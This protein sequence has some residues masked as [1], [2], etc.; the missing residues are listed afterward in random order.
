MR[1]LTLNMRGFGIFSEPTEIDFTDVELF[2]LTGPT[3]SGKTTVL[4]GICF[5]LY[6]AIPR[7]GEG[8][9]APVVNQQKNEASVVLTFAFNDATYSVARR[10]RRTAKGASTPDASLERDGTVL[11]ANASAVTAKVQELLG[12]DFRQFTTCVLLPQGEFARFLNEKQGKRQELL[13]ALLDL[14]LYDVIAGLATGRAREAEGKLAVL[15][16]QLV[17]LARITETDLEGLRTRQK[18]LDALSKTLGKSLAQLEQLGI[19]ATK[20]RNALETLTATRS[21]LV[22]LKPPRGWK[23]IGDLGKRLAASKDT[24]ATEIEAAAQEHTELLAVAHPARTQVA[25]YLEARSKEAATTVRITSL[26]NEVIQTKAVAV[27]EAEALALAERALEAA[28]NEDRAAHIRAGLKL[29]DLCPV[30]GEKITTLRASASGGILDTRSKEA[31]KARARSNKAAA[32]LQ[33]FES[34]LTR[35]EDRLRDL[36]AELEG[37]DPADAL[38]SQLHA[39]DDHKAG[40]DRARDRLANA[41][42]TAEFLDKK[43]VELNRRLEEVREGLQAVWHDL[44]PLGPPL[45]DLAQPVEAWDAILTWREM[46]LPALDLEGEQGGQRLAAINAEIDEAQAQLGSDLEAAGLD[47][48]LA[49]AREALAVALT[50]VTSDIAGVE[51]ARE[52][53]EQVG[54]ERDRVNA[55]RELAKKLAGELA[56]NKFKKWIFDEVFRALVEGANLRLA[57][58]TSGQYE[59]AVT[60]NDFEV[61]DRFAADKRRGVKSLSGGETFLVSL[62]LAIALADEV[63]A[64]AGSHVA[65]DSFFLDEGFG[66][67]DTESLDVV[68]RVIAELGAAGKT[69]GIVTHVEELADQMPVRY[70]VRR[71][72]GSGTVTQVGAA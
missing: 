29:G 62:A 14:G 23:E 32:T 24:V 6:G 44:T 52:A 64:A 9:V 48:D 27:A 26:V 33:T 55:E 7:H 2:A 56:A 59:L 71:V 39:I 13:G 21:V 37:I 25:R 36:A 69:V 63:A 18:E 66:T 10:V 68:A 57:D 22:G 4:D 61:I 1:P 16:Q 42:S 72:G 28:I 70:E 47:T 43:T 30:C 58:L 54:L 46:R 15:S 5:A 20:Q 67:L 45:L 41:R 17:E 60:D 51:E 8:S 40:L 11:A 49:G 50:T 34:E 65:L 53:V 31:D 35:E 38:A 19:D 3:G 12:L